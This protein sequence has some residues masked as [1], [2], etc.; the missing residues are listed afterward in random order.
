MSDKN[1]SPV[2]WYVG[3]YLLRF[4][5]LEEDKINRGQVTITTPLSSHTLTMHTDL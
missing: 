1:I 5:E 2:G 3:S 4:I